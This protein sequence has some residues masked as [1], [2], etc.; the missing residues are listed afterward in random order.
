M[1]SDELAVLAKDAFD[2]IDRLRDAYEEC[3]MAGQS[4]ALSFALAAGL[5]PQATY[6]VSETAKYLGL[7]RSTISRELRSGR[8]RKITHDGLAPRI[9]CDEVDRWMRENAR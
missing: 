9:S 6:N 1:T 8:L 2:A 3:R 4:R 7:D 5:P